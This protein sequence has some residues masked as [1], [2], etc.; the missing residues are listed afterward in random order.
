MSH[1]RRVALKLDLSWSYKRHFAVFAGAQQYAQKQGWQLILDEFVEDTLY[2]CAKSPP[3]EGIIARATTK[4]AQRAKRLQIPLVNVWLSSPASQ[5]VPS[6]VPDFFTAGRLRAEHLLALGRRTFAALTIEGDR[7]QDLE[8]IAFQ[9]TLQK[10]GLACKAVKSARGSFKTV[11]DWQEF[12]GLIKAWLK[13]WELPVGVYVGT[14]AIGR[15]VIEACRKFRWRIPEDVAII[16]GRNE[17]LECEISH[18]TISSMEFGY[19]R[20]GS[21]A[22]KLLEQYMDGMPP[23]E[24]SHL[25]SPRGLVIRESTNVIF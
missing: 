12:H 24:Q 4:L 16:A 18:P 21:A 3:Y 1:C 9:Q 7:G 2:R 25:I 10:N 23:A 14:E 5:L 13:S 17:E 20:V 19:D 8:L 11:Q 22:A 6:V 15:I